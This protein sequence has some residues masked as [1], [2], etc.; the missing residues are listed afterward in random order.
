MKDPSNTKHGRKQV[1]KEHK[2]KVVKSLSEAV[3]KLKKKP[4]LLSKPT[5]ASP[6]A[7]AKAGGK[8]NM[9]AKGWKAKKQLLA[10]KSS[11]QEGSVADP[12][13]ENT[14]KPVKKPVG[15]VT[16]S[17]KRKPVVNENDPAALKKYR[18]SIKP[19]FELVSCIS[20]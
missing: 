6:N 3:S 20:P 12:K 16:Q 1:K 11:H 18:Q 4:I 9:V 8:G 7:G 17:K 19:N 14:K 2:Q 10:P 13:A 5:K 15:F